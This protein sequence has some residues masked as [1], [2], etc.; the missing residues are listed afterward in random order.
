MN[1]DILQKLAVITPAYNEWDNLEVLAPEIVAQLSLFHPSSRWIV[2]SEANP[3]P[4]L[5]S[6]LM[7]FS[8]Q[9]RV[10]P[11]QASY[12][13]F[14][15]AIQLGLD[16]VQS[17]DDVVVFLDGDNSHDP[18]H[19]SL[20]AGVLRDRSEVDVVISSRYVTGGES[21]NP[22]ILRLM[23]MTLNV[24]YRLVLRLEARDISTNYKA[25]RSNLIRG[26]KLRSRNFEA[27]E[28]LLL[29]AQFRKGSRL[30]M[31]EIPDHFRNRLHGES[32][33]RLAQ[34]I[35]T[36][37]ISLWRLRRSLAKNNSAVRSD[38]CR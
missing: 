38:D 8:N 36:Y 31:V 19:I 37:L 26:V 13:T 7:T 9:I 34:F 4:D 5:A 29:L 11:R 17:D 3:D 15:D 23:S 16:E 2:V 21:D 12:E 24:V 1:H 33:R 27:V 35:G 18:R 30:N 20:L 10:F 28:E 32:K 22:R 25:Y 14:A 6:R